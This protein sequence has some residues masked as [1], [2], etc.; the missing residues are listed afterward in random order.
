M[1]DREATAASARPRF[2]WRRVSMLALVV[3]AVV[4]AAVGGVLVGRSTAPGPNI[5]V[6][7]GPVV[8]EAPG[9]D[10]LSTS[11][12]IEPDR[13]LVDG[14]PVTPP[15]VFTAAA[16]LDDA[17]TTA[18]GYRLTRSGLDGAEVAAGLAAVFGVDGSVVPTDSGWTV[19]GADTAAATLTVSDDPELSW[20]FTDPAATEAA[21]GGVSISPRRAKEVASALLA[22]VGVDLDSVDWQSNRFDDHLSVTATQIVDGLRSSLFWQVN[23][24]QN[25]AV[26]SASGFAAEFV[27]VPG[28][29]VVGAATAVRRSALPTWSLLGP[30]PVVSSTNATAAVTSDLPVEKLGPDDRPALQVGVS[31]IVVVDATLGL[32]QFWQPDGGLLAL[33]A[34]RLVG[35]DGTQWTVIAVTGDYVDFVDQPYPG[36]P[37]PAP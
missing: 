15:A 18:S 2:G 32:A 25:D 6:L 10:P 4:A 33:P 34:Y 21:Q 22:D 9:V 11:G 37:P 24:G 31:S 27:E 12:V 8:Q 29:E 28:Y 20:T 1:A 3:L 16:D 23:F 5:V 36:L 14:V 17:A 26:V 35:D 19:S 30:T 13:L 7:P